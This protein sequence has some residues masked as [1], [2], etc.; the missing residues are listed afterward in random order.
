MLQL[1]HYTKHTHRGTEHWME[2]LRF[3]RVFRSSYS[4]FLFSLSAWEGK[5]RR[6]SSRSL[7]QETN[8]PLLVTVASTTNT[9]P[10]PITTMRTITRL[11]NI[12]AKTC[13]TSLYSCTFNFASS[14][15]LI[16]T[17]FITPYV[18]LLHGIQNRPRL[19]LQI[20][21][22]NVFNEHWK[23]SSCI[24]GWIVFLVRVLLGCLLTSTESGN[25][26]MLIFQF[27]RSHWHD[28]SG[29]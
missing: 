10:K 20:K 21:A 8:S 26:P 11:F 17:I 6:I 14:I 24:A 22:S 15:Q 1:W 18:T 29:V 25:I 16:F 5:H 12:T 3:S 7:V 13:D 19:T 4:L 9:P 28:N 27:W 23:I 2:D